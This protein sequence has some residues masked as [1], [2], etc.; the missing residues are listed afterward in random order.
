MVAWALSWYRAPWWEHVMEENGSPYGSQEA[1]RDREWARVC[2]SPSRT[3]L[4]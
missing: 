2:I 4:Q 1:K 3:P